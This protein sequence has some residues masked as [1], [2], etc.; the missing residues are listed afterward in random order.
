[1][2]LMPGQKTETTG[3]Q[4]YLEGVPSVSNKVKC[5]NRAD[6]GQGISRHVEAAMT[7]GHFHGSEENFPELYN[8]LT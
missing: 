2:Y 6:L 1:M 8:S 3:K 7:N 5:N 4:S